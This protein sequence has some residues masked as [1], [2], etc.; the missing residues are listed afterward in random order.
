[1]LG[2]NHSY[3]QQQTFLAI[4]SANTSGRLSWELRDGVDVGTDGLPCVASQ[5]WTVSCS[6]K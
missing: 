4:T 1:M 6:D 3:A 5:I 2:C